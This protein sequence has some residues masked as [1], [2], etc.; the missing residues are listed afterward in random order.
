[1][2]KRKKYIKKLLRNIYFSFT[3]SLLLIDQVELHEIYFLIYE[4]L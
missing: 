2:D 4:H 1:M 3:I